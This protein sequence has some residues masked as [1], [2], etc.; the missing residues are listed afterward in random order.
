MVK[1]DLI[2]QLSYW[3]L[4]RKS[5]TTTLDILADLYAAGTRSGVAVNWKTALEAMVALR[6]ALVIAQGLAQVPFKLMR[7]VNGQRVP[8]KDHPLYGLMHDSPN[9]WQTSYDFRESMGMHLVFCGGAFAWI[10]R[11]RGNIMELLPYEPQMVT[12]DRTGWELSYKVHDEFGKEIPIPKGEMWHVRGP[13]WNTWMGLEGVRLAREAIGLGV[14]AERYGAQF[15]GNGAQ[16]GGLLSTEQVLS[17]EKRNELRESWEKMVGGENKL[18]TAVLWAGMKWTSMAVENDAA[19]FLETRKFQIEEVCRAFGVNPLR[20]YYSDKTSTYAS[21]EQFFL[22]HVIHDLMPWY[23]RVEMSANKYL[24]TEK[25]RAAGYYFKFMVNGLMRGAMKDRMEFY[26]GMY[27][28]GA[29]NPNEARE[30]ED[31]N[32]Y[33]GG[34]KYRV[35]LNMADP[36]VDSPEKGKDDGTV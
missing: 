3:W 27:G 1:P 17:A 10:N 22:S 12:V 32:P 13:S 28:M 4:N 19:Q 20:V 23:V 21:A 14:A 6:C 30:L 36:L 7:E 16:P 31:M 24:L 11:P 18:K 29:M 8:A 26:K 2:S 35:P 34:D 9:D 15:F 5:S 25:E 33:E